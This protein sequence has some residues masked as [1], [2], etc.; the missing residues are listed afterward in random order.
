MKRE[1]RRTHLNANNSALAMV[2]RAFDTSVTRMPLPAYMSP[3]VLPFSDFTSI[4]SGI[5]LI[6]VKNANFMNI[7]LNFIRYAIPC[8]LRYNMPMFGKK[9]FPKITQNS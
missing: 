3:E 9:K 2:Y 8:I 6:F 1:S 5:L 7:L 4:L